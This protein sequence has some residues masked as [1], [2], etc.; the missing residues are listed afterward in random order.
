M[1]KFMKIISMRV[2]PQSAFRNPKLKEVEGR[3][4]EIETEIEPGKRKL[5]SL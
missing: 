3:K 5:R 4:I 1:K 2:N